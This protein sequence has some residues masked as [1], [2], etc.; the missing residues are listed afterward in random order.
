MQTTGDKQALA[1]AH[2]MQGILAFNQRDMDAARHHLE[3]SLALAEALGNLGAQAAALNN[4]A[5]T[6]GAVGETARAVAL[7]ETA[8]RLCS[9]QGDRHREA[10]L[11]NSLADLLHAAGRVEASMIHLKQAAAIFAEIGGQDTHGSRR[12]GSWW[13]GSLENW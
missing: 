12:Y 10:A 9:S 11:H 6:W 4:L 7:A 3:N 5:L 1:Q 2:N 8:L 13:S